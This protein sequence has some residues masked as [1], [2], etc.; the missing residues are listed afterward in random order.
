[1][2]VY[3]N[4]YMLHPLVVSLIY[5]EILN[6]LLP[7]RRKV[8]DSLF[9]LLVLLLFALALL[10][11]SPLCALQSFLLPSIKKK[12]KRNIQKIL[13]LSSR[14]KIT[15]RGNGQTNYEQAQ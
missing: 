2:V 13:A 1:M 7:V 11:L 5:F 8:H 12:Q 3:I 15:V 10:H 14:C 4:A 9:E 6:T